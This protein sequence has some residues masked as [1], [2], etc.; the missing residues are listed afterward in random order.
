MMGIFVTS[1]MGDLAKDMVVYWKDPS[2]KKKYG[3]MPHYSPCEYEAH[4]STQPNTVHE[5]YGV[6]LLTESQPF[7]ASEEL[8]FI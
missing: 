4:C 6:V 8:R 3:K 2:S 1:A 5:A 7:R